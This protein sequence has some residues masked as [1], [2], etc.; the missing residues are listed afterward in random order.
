MPLKTNGACIKTKLKN[1][2]SDEDEEED[3]EDEDEE[4]E[5]DSEPS[6][7][8]ST[9]RPR[10]ARNDKDRQHRELARQISRIVRK[11]ENDDELTKEEEVL[12]AKNPKL[13]DDIIRRHKKRK[14]TELR[15]QEIE[16][17]PTVLAK[18]CERMARAI[19]KAKYLL[20]YT[21]AGI[22]TAAN[23]PDYRGPN[24]VWTCLDE[25]R[26]IATCDLARAE[27]TYTHMALFTLFK[28]GKLKHIV[29]QNCDGL[30]LRSGIPRYS[31]S[32]VHGNMFIEVCKHC[33]P[34]RPYLRLF[35]VTERT[36]KNKH[37][38]MRRCHI[39]GNSLIDTIVHF[40]ER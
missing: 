5:E 27:P 40:G 28:K 15:K 23:I 7:T 35:D 39:C 24:G 20:V 26:E 25:G 11:T 14:T 30:H 32:E 36:S 38:T 22:S 33:K 21:G 16:D 4:D 9:L 19:Q 29:S 8:R 31:L 1:N 37:N 17:K 10:S 12:L 34:M 18:K 13:F 3:D 6:I 2:E